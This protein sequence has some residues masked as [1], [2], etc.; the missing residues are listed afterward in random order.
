LA[1]KKR[2]VLKVQKVCLGKNGPKSPYHE[3]KYLRSFTLEHLLIGCHF[4][5]ESFAIVV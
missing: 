4:L 1:R 5:D 3:E 2:K